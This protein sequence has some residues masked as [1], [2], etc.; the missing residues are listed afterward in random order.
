MSAEFRY[1]CGECRYRTPWL[2]ESEG[3]WQLAEHYRRRHPR[4]GPGGEF[5]IRRGWRDL[6][7]RLFR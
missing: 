5:E 3:A 4:V 1:R 7:G 2:D 6:F